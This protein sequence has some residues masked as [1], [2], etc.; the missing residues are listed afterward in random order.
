MKIFIFVVKIVKNCSENTNNIHDQLKSALDRQQ[1]QEIEPESVSSMIDIQG[2]SNKS[3]SAKSLS[4]P[5]PNKKENVKHA[6][7]RELV[8][9]TSTEI[10]KDKENNVILVPKKLIIDSQWDRIYEQYGNSVDEL[11]I[12]KKKPDSLVRIKDSVAV[13]PSG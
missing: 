6:I 10:K 8:P 4:Q 1:T 5:P 12:S 3:E 7:D 11:T 9:E 2:S 13:L